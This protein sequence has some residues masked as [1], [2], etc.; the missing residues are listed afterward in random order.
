MI[1]SC[2]GKFHAFA[3]AEQM[4]RLQRLDKFYTTYAS[5]K[6]KLLARFVN[7]KDKEQIPLSKLSTLP[8]LAIP[9]K[10]WP[11]SA[12][13]WNDLF[14][15]WVSSKIGATG[16]RVFVGWSG[17][18]V[19]SMEKAKA[20]GMVTILE[21]GSSHIAYQNSLLREEFAQF[22][23]KF[24]IDPRVIE[25]ELREY[26]LAD[27]ISVPS[28]FV[29]DS[30]LSKGIPASKLLLNPY[31]TSQL[32]QVGEREAR[33][34]HKKFTVLYLGTLSIRKGLIYLFKALEQLPLKPE[35]FDVLF[36]GKVED[37]LKPLINQYQKANWK[38][39]GHLD[40]N[41]LREYIRF[42]H[43][44]VQPSIEEGLSMVIP[45]MMACG[46]GVIASANTGGANIIRT[47]DNGYI[48]PVRSP[49]A[50]SERIL[51]LFE[52]REKLAA[53]SSA[54]MVSI[55]NGFTWADYGERYVA[56]LQ[57]IMHG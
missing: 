6:N 46:V 18:S 21:R 42:C 10:R 43:V 9:M 2:S 17:M 5:Q 15:R 13:V 55:S 11:A 47:G 50:I 48:V 27:Y 4:S 23:V 37:E 19:R 8:A 35:D 32:F 38:F 34:K 24:S 41:S 40:H 28:Y 25:K 16:S 52:H 1:I 53:I 22:G 29:R 49:E 3:L 39:L 26:E 30:F 14:D 31:G 51:D 56:N 54:A 12:F 33:E 20:K 7:R 45:Q 36:I 44:A 57:K